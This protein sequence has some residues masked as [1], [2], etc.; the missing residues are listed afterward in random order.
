M[1]IVLSRSRALHSVVP[2]PQRGFTLFEVM[3]AIAIFAILGIAANG[4]LSQTVRTDEKVRDRTARLAEVQ[5]AIGILERDALQAVARP[6]RDELGGSRPALQGG[7]QDMLEFTRLGW[8]N[9][10][11]RPRAE[12]QRVA[13]VLD[14]KQL[15]RLYWNVLDRADGSLPV[16]Q[17]LLTGVAEASVEF[18]DSEGQSQSFWP[19]ESAALTAL[20]R[21]LRWR[22]NVEP[23]GE[24][25]RLLAL[26]DTLPG[27]AV[28]AGQDGA[29]G[30]RQG[31]ANGQGGADVSGSGADATREPGG[32]GEGAVQQ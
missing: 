7:L 15:L 8:R 25:E 13:Y 18:I 20:P 26:P 16:R 31:G 5:R 2:M 27:A 14:N 32:S 10:A 11:G 3:V 19:V 24:I 4:L 28:A 12:L 21:A 17:V 23:Y 29:G 9:P 6:V 22:L 1:N 30:G